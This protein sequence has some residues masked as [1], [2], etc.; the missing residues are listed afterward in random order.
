MKT[1]NKSI[2]S[3]SS[4]SSSPSHT[5]NIPISLY[6]SPTEIG[7]PEI[8]SGDRDIWRFISRKA[9][10]GGLISGCPG[11]QSIIVSDSSLIFFTWLWIGNGVSIFISLFSLCFQFPISKNKNKKPKS[12]TDSEKSTP[13]LNLSVPDGD[14]ITEN[15]R[16]RE[17]KNASM[18]RKMRSLV[19]KWENRNPNLNQATDF[20]L[21]KC[22]NFLIPCD[23]S[24]WII[25]SRSFVAVW[26]RVPYL[27]RVSC[28]ISWLRLWTRV[29]AGWFIYYIVVADGTRS[30]L[31]INS[32]VFF[33]ILFW[34]I[35]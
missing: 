25:A 17:E 2:I 24:H 26:F 15:S 28:G 9:A 5:I 7:R 35:N 18:R 31:L 33:F 13:E 3:P 8:P 6:D 32:F 16:E 27:S 10:V 34:K 4:S 29:V 19:Q 20:D 12:K 14:Y 11:R 22:P 23:R 30:L 1:E 21:E